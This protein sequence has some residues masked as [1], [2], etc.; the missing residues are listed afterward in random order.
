MRSTEYSLVI[1]VSVM[2][3]IY[4]IHETDQQPHS[5]ILIIMAHPLDVLAP[6]RF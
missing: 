1:Y 3:Y 4:Y 6:L 2:R 5:D